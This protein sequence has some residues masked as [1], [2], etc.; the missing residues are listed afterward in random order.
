MD[1]HVIS[2]WSD[3]LSTGVDEI[4]SDH[5]SLFQIFQDAYWISQTQTDTSD[6]N[7]M[8][9][10]LLNYTEVHFARE[11]ALMEVTPYPYLDKHRDIHHELIKN[12]KEQI[13]LTQ[14]NKQS[15]QQF[16]L[17]LKDWFIEHIN[18]IDKR[19]EPYT[20]MHLESIQLA[21]ENIGSLTA[22]PY[23]HIFLVDDDNAFSKLLQ[24]MTE[25]AGLKATAYNSSSEFLHTTICN[26]DIIVLDLNMPDKDGIEVMRELA[27]Q[28][29]TPTFILVSGFDERVLQS[30]R[31]FA[32]SRQLHVAD[33]LSKPVYF[34]NFIQVIRKTFN[35][36]TTDYIQSNLADFTPSSDLA[37][38]EN[39]ARSVGS[40]N[41]ISLAEL[42]RGLEQQEFIAYLQPQVKFSDGSLCGVEALVRWQHPIRGLVF[43]DKIIPLV[44]KNGL[45]AELTQ[46]VI[47]ESI[48]ALSKLITAGIKVSISIN[49]SAKN[50][51]DLRFPERL[52]VLLKAHDL[53]PEQ[54]TL[55]LT[56][57]EIITDTSIALDI[58]NRLRMK[59]FSLSI[60]DFGTGDSSLKKLYQSPF[61][62]LKIDQHFVS[63]M[64]D[65]Q[66]ANSIVRVC[67]ILANEFNMTT[68]AEGIETQE[69]WNK[70]AEMGCDIA[71]G[72]LISKPLPVDQLI[73]WANSYKYTYDDT[74]VY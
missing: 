71:Q 27:D 42:K 2:F 67:T 52:D 15:A 6:L 33:A 34:E 56:E 51:V 44:E 60:D 16:I 41:D 54:F 43:P 12:L 53:E 47:F 28:G 17:F 68:V 55:E 59:G 21:T 25:E 10:N 31:Q 22:L 62:E 24:A 23:C 73:D 26:Q 69:V 50:I 63:R 14:N 3:D 19:V 45:M 35:E 29:I 40:K 8:M 72:Y 48:K 18:G 32:E 70:L 36:K 20:R 65:D 13:V 38:P 39:S 37:I 1:E 74:H 61:S 9:A 7:G 30:A 49:I 46:T 66:E 5:K 58:F 64:A 4:D 11:E 57:S